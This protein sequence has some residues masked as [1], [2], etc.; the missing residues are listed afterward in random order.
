MDPR[1]I[2]EREAAVRALASAHEAVESLESVALDGSARR[3]VLLEAGDA[4]ETTLRRWLRDS[5]AVAIEVRL[6]A[7]APDEMREDD[8]LG[9]LRQHDLISLETAAAVHDLFEMRIRLGGGSAP[10]P[11]DEQL[12]RRA[13]HRL[14]HELHSAVPPERP[15]RPPDG[16]DET[17]VHAVPPPVPPVQR[18]WLIAGALV[19]VVLIAAAVA[20]SLANRQDPR[21]AEGFALFRSGDY[22]EAASLF[23]RYAEDNP[24]DATP[25][26]YLARIHRRMGRPQLAGE[27][28]RLALEM[29]PR[30][31]D[32]HAELGFLLL[33]TG[34][35]D[36]A[37]ERFRA[38]LR[39]DPENATAWIGLVR[40]LRA[41]DG[42]EAADSVLA[43]AP[44]SVREAF[45]R[46]AGAQ[47]AD[48]I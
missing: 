25:H 23:W 27:E 15:T 20:V 43:A 44:E 10:A 34:R 22:A 16:S 8:I 26:L 1:T 4:V 14:D 11:A 13:V 21:L 32:V 24:D 29:A 36:V 12:A 28:L 7:Q 37:V 17:L 42:A 40:A 5:E 2:A 45:G 19:L 47:P 38:A 3:R 6:R 33:D 9:Q 18:S 48:T 39:M 31:A 46:G 35:D 30:D 41:S